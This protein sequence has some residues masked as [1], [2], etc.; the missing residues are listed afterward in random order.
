[1]APLRSRP[2]DALGARAVLGF[3]FGPV[4]RPAREF[5]DPIINVRVEGDCGP[6]TLLDED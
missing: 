3:E 4:E 2:T 1:M 5:H 6:V